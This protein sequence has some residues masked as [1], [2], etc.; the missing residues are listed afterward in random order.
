MLQMCPLSPPPGHLPSCILGSR[1]LRHLQPKTVVTKRIQQPRSELS[2]SVRTHEAKLLAVMLRT[3]RLTWVFGEPGTDKSALLK[4]GVMPLLQ[5]H[6]ERGAAHAAPNAA[7]LSERRRRPVQPRFEVAIYFDDWAQAP[8][9]TLKRRIMDVVPAIAAEA[10]GSPLAV[11]L[12][13][14]HQQ[15]G[16]HFLF[17]LDRFEEYLVMA[18]DEGEIGP[19][20][21]ELVDAIVHDRLPVSFLIALDEV[22]RSRLERFRARIPGFDHDVL[23]LSPVAEQRD[24][25]TVLP[26]SPADPVTHAPY[27]R[28]PP[29]RMPTK[30][31]DVYALIESTLSKGKARDQS[32][33]L[34]ADVDLD[35]SAMITPADQPAADATPL[36]NDAR[37]ES[38]RQ[39]AAG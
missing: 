2:P 20:A 5:R 32:S 24:Q 29:A 11:T 37:V 7:V 34:H 17:L 36:A 15:R 22:A 30:V 39:P 19:F 35:V 1:A 14:L 28:R 27:P 21:N 25:A 13:Q 8:L 10:D 38:G 3:S 23:R 9:S 31:E 6:R 4:T 12:R 18:P 16:L 26:P 33:D